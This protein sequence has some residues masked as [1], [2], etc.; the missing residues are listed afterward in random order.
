M[1]CF[2]FAQRVRNFLHRPRAR[3]VSRATIW[4][5]IRHVWRD[6]YSRVYTATRCFFHTGEVPLLS[7]LHVERS[8]T[9]KTA[10][11]EFLQHSDVSSSAYCIGQQSRSE[12]MDTKK[13]KKADIFLIIE[14]SHAR[15]SLLT[16][17]SWLSTFRALE[18]GARI[19]ISNCVTRKKLT[20]TF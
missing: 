3:L 16:L 14:I 4:T 17:R 15:A 12:E 2:L 6:E 5:R 7:R 9:I 18:N 20:K 13:K 11:R 8:R 1:G 10:F 19:T